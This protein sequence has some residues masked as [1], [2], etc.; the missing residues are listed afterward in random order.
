MV[1]V[2]RA[3]PRWFLLWCSS[4]IESSSEWKQ[5]NE[6]YTSN[7]PFSLDV[8]SNYDYEEIRIGF[9]SIDLLSVQMSRNNLEFVRIR[10]LIDFSYHLQQLRR[11]RAAINVSIL[12]D[13]HLNSFI[14]YITICKSAGSSCLL[15]FRCCSLLGDHNSMVDG[16]PLL[17]LP[18]MRL[19]HG[20]CHFATFGSFLFR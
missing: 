4:P 12:V 1:F 16:L 3:Y 20:Q 11:G 5:R 6:S 8:S 10:Q 13:H 17:A 18:L 7:F 19:C 2:Y 9:D 14:R 15:R